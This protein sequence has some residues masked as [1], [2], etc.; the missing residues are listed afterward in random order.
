MEEIGFRSTRIRT[1][2]NSLITV[3]NADMAKAKIDNM[4]ERLFRRTRTTLGV[5]YDTPTPKMEAFVEGIKQIILANE[6]T[7]KDLY[8][9]AFCGYGP[10]SLDILVN[11][12]IITT[13]Y[14]QEIFERQNIFLEIHRLAEELKI[15]FAFP[16]QTLYLR[17]EETPIHQVNS[18]EL[19]RL[20]KEFGP[21]GS[22]AHSKG[23]GFYRPPYM[24]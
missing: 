1:F 12:F 16:T 2:Y 20:P 4:G 17:K 11:F 23:Q 9:V 8:Y 3:P 21:K 18:E 6:H 24:E 14:Q 7:R 19:K 22:L 10:A 15:E 5:A 13:E